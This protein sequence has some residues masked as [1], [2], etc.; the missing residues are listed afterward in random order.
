MSDNRNNNFDDGEDLIFGDEGD[1]QWIFEGLGSDNFDDFL[2][3]LDRLNVIRNIPE[4][5]PGRIKFSDLFKYL[6]AFFE[7][8]EAVYFNPITLGVA[9]TV[10]EQVRNIIDAYDVD[11]FERIVVAKSN[12][13]TLILEYK[14]DYINARVMPYSLREIS[15]L[16]DGITVFMDKDGNHML[17]SIYLEDFIL[18]KMKEGKEEQ[19]Q[20]LERFRKC[21]QRK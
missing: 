4:I 19:C 6:D 21:V 11:W 20:T 15:D 8:Y 18:V 17:L 14:V 3:D 12:P 5:A 2:I 10:R 9:D 13:T 7:N 1:E 16:T